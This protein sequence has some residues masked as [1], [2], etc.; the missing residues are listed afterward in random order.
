MFFKNNCILVYF[1]ADS[2]GVLEIKKFSVDMP[3]LWGGVSFLH[4]P[5][6]IHTHDRLDKLHSALVEAQLK[7]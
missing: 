7:T 3:F 5:F 2:D 6:Y 4:M 1:F